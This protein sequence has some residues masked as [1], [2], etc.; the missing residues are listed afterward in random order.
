[1]VLTGGNHLT[2]ARSL[3]R[4]VEGL[5]DLRGLGSLRGRAQ[6]LT[7]KV[8]Y[9][10]ESKNLVFWLGAKAKVELGTLR[11]RIFVST[12]ILRLFPSVILEIWEP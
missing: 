8:H 2:T 11:C 7:L 4:L 1:M 10:P 6:A 5:R 9:G 12:T 3:A